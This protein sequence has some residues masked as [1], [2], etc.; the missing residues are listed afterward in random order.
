MGIF[1]WFSGKKKEKEM[2]PSADIL[3]KMIRPSEEKTKKNKA[4]K[5]WDPNKKLT[6]WD[7][8]DSG[9]LLV[10]EYR[11]KIL[12]ELFGMQETEVMQRHL[13]RIIA[14]WQKAPKDQW[15]QIAKDYMDII[16]TE[17]HQRVPFV[18]GCM[19]M[20]EKAESFVRAT[21]SS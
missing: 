5:R 21:Q 6:S 4:K 18:C 20:V 9:M 12:K 8:I 3:K 11:T 14:L 13:R 10:A 16:P 15:Q 19:S 17:L 2:H 7:D 1:D